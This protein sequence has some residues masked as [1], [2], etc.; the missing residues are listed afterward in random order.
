MGWTVKLLLGV[1]KQLLPGGTKAETSEKRMEFMQRSDMMEDRGDLQV[2]RSS[3]KPSG[4]SSAPLLSLS[5]SAV[6]ADLVGGSAPLL[7]FAQ[8]MSH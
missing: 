1:F 5:L 6:R 7:L 2:Q 8:E 3:S 4:R